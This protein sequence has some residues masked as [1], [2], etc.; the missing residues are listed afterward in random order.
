M[1]KSNTETSDKSGSTQA[2]ILQNSKP[3]VT[4]APAGI[5]AVQHITRSGRLR[6]KDLRVWNCTIQNVKHFFK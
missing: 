1:Q 5:F 4:R 3:A 2:S 6:L